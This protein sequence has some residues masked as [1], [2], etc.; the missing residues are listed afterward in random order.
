M[1]IFEGRIS[2]GARVGESPHL[3]VELAIAMYVRSDRLGPWVSWVQISYL[4]M[5]CQVSSHLGGSATRGPPCIPPTPLHEAV[6][7]LLSSGYDLTS[8]VVHRPGSGKVYIDRGCW[9]T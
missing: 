3:S 1:H 8:G 4:H 6:T 2:C 5:L 7:Y 9:T